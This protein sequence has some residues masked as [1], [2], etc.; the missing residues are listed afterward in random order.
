[1]KAITYAVFSAVLFFSMAV[2]AQAPERF[3][4]FSAPF[5]EPTIIVDGEEVV[6]DEKC[7]TN[8]QGSQDCKP[9]AGTS[10]LLRDGRFLYLNA[11]EG[12]ENVEFSIVSEFGEVSVNDQSR[13]LSLDEDDNPTWIRP[14]PVD[15]GA[16]P[17]GRDSTTLTDGFLDTAESNTD[18]DGALFCS[19]V[20]ALADGSILAAGGTDYYFEPGVEG[21]PFGVTELEGLKAARIFDPATN[22]W[23]QSGNMSFGR[24]YPTMV[25]L[26]DGDVFIAS[27]VTKLIKPVYP[28]DPINSGRNVVQTETY[29]P[30]SGLWS[31]NPSTADRSLPLYPRL[32]LLPNGHVLYNGGGQ[33]FNPAGEGYDQALW[34]I[35]SA[36]DPETQTWT[37]LGYAGLPLRLNEAGLGALT[38]TLNATNFNQDQ[39]QRLV[40]EVSANPAGLLE[41][42]TQAEVSP[43][44]VEQ[45]VGAGMRGSTFSAMLP[46][47][48]DENGEYHVAEFLTAGGVPTYV[49]AGSPG[50]Y[51]PTDMSRIDTVTVNGDDMRYESRVTGPLNQPRWYGQSVAMPD[52]SVMVFSGGTRDHVAIPGLEGAI[53]QAE[54][55]DPQT[56]TWQRMASGN[57]MRTYHNTE[58]LM[59]DGRVLVGGHA[60]I[61]TAYLSHISLEDFGFAPND[62]RDPSFE[63]YTPPYALRDDRP[64]IRRAPTELSADGSSFKIQVTLPNRVDEVMLIRRTATTHVVDG[65]QRSVV[66]PIVQRRGANLT[67]RM[68]DNKA[69]VPA[70]PY[71]LFVSF[72]AEDGMRVPSEA[73]SVMVSDPTMACFAD[74]TQQST[75]ESPASNDSGG[76]LLDSVTR[77]IGL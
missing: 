47:R 69:V 33:S 64:V 35:V 60:P 4:T 43:T 37:D 56:E 17:D 62:G 13:V 2:S 20:V 8:S 59:P 55:F 75:E 36:Y 70:G 48:P 11:L 30:C 31:Q 28:Q 25:T 27:G 77:L 53:R 6:T 68:P 57:R 63:I 76:G 67:V 34:N 61:N 38:T 18:N 5:A 7:L 40:G 73:A 32:H 45:A 52:G 39:L 66:L 46:L 50:G 23:S 44:A 22:T 14:S 51:F 54:R 1:M 3:G 49:V 71:M 29:D 21:I 72:E 65:D 16:N 58:V 24:W 12:T 19:D 10:V 74:A 26:A 9:A 41:E 42:V 15:A